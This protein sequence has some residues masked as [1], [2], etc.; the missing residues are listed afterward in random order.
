MRS[1]GWTAAANF[2]G[3]VQPEGR[4]VRLPV[5]E[6]NVNPKEHD[7]GAC[8]TTLTREAAKRT[9]D[10]VR[11]TSNVYEDATLHKHLLGDDDQRLF[12]EIVFNHAERWLDEVDAIGL[13]AL[14]TC[15][16]LISDHVKPLRLFL[17]GTAA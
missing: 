15:Q 14:Q 6:A 13:N 3:N 4:L 10:S 16:V 12:L 11:E 7:Y 8:K 9:W 2:Y 1:A 5:F 17:L